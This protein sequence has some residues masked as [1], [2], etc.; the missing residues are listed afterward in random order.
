MFRQIEILDYLESQFPYEF[1]PNSF[2]TS[3]GDECVAVV[4]NGGQN[5]KHVKNPTIQFLVRSTKE[6]TCE[7]ISYELFEFFD[8]K[9]N[10]QI[11]G[12]QVVHSR[13][14]QSCP[15]YT[16]KDENGRHIYSVNIIFTVSNS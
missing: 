11:N 3:S 8:Y 6:S 5:G 15:L 12:K 13:G 2:K 10:F 9:T 16:G 4:L 1:D 7:Q 14:Q